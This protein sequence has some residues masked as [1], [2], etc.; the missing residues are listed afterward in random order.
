MSFVRVR[1]K[2]TGTSN[3]DV[4]GVITYK[5]I[6]LTFRAG[7]GKTARLERGYHGSPLGWQEMWRRTCATSHRRL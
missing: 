7:S 1:T 2:G 4:K 5:R 3:T 6:L